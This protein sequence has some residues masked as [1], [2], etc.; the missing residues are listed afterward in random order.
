MFL[1]SISLFLLS[2]MLMAPVDAQ[3]EDQEARALAFVEALGQ[4]DPAVTG[5]L[6]KKSFARG[7]ACRLPLGPTWYLPSK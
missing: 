5:K 2:L 6:V 7:G 4:S 1:R 3:T